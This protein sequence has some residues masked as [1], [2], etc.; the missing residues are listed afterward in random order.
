MTNKQLENLN[1]KIAKKLGWTSFRK[2]NTPEP[3]NTRRTIGV[4]PGNIRHQFV[5]YFT[6]NLSYALQIVDWAIAHEYD[7][8]L[9]KRAKVPTFYRA[10]FSKGTFYGV[11]EGTL[12]AM[13]I[14]MAFLNIK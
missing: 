4:A 13:A 14:C 8:E 11:G 5:P 2:E 9:G 12:P 1:V 3:L 10:Y 7:F 6:N